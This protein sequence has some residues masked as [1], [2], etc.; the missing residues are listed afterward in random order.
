MCRFAAILDLRFKLR[1]CLE[2]EKNVFTDMLTIAAESVTPIEEESPVRPQPPNKKP[3]TLFSYMTNSDSGSEQ[4][5]KSQSY[6]QVDEYLI[7]KIVP[8]QTDPVNFWRKNQGKYPGLAKPAREV[9]VVP[10]SSAPV[11]RLF[12]IASR[13]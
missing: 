1:W 10:A 3:K 5:T 2:A 6:N 9:L 11:E 12:T 13:L 8:M 4:Q 7:A